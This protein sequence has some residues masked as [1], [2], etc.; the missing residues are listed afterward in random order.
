MIIKVIGAEIVKHCVEK[1]GW[2]NVILVFILFYFGSSAVA[3][4]L[5]Y[6]ER[7]FSFKKTDS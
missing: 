6:F 3:S 2:I 7:N 4:V 1:W 5:D